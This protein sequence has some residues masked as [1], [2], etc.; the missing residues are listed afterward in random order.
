VGAVGGMAKASAA[1][2]LKLMINSNCISHL[3]A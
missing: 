3:H 1:A 2:V